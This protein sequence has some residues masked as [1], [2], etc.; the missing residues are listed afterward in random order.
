MKLF[1]RILRRCWERWYNGSALLKKVETQAKVITEL[2]QRIV[3]LEAQLDANSDG[4][5]RNRGTKITHD[6]LSDYAKLESQDSDFFINADDVVHKE[7][8]NAN[9]AIIKVASTVDNVLHIK[10]CRAP[11]EIKRIEKKDMVGVAIS[12]NQARAF[13][14]LVLKLMKENFGVI[15]VLYSEFTP[16]HCIRIAIPDANDLNPFVQIL[17]IHKKKLAETI[18]WKRTLQ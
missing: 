17:K 15:R 11:R 7:Y 8:I 6:L 10:I 4:A 18:Q 1:D 12:R 13:S 2:E 5:K 3:Q 16:T 14:S 9:T